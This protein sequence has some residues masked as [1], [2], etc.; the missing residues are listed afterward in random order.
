MLDVGIGY[1]II[2]GF[3]NYSYNYHM[4]NSVLMGIKG[5]ASSRHGICMG[6]IM[7]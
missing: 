6:L 5:L 7:L 1:K 3:Y 2:M 4:I